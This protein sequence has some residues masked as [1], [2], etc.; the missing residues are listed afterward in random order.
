M[1]DSP[2]DTPH[3][4]VKNKYAEDLQTEQSECAAKVLEQLRT[5]I[6]STFH[7]VCFLTSV[8]QK[9]LWHLDM[10]VE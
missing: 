1:A 8:Q 2:I 3:A 6:F 5:F 7:H 9:W 4:E 10:P